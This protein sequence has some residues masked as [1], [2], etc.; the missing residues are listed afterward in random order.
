M[1]C[2]MLKFVEIK[3]TL[4][5]IINASKKINISKNELTRA[6]DKK[7]F[8]KCLKDKK[9][10]TFIEVKIIGI[11]FINLNCGVECG[12]GI[13]RYIETQ[14]LNI[15]KNSLV[16]RISGTKFG[17]Y[18]NEIDLESIKDIIEE[19]IEIAK[20]LN[21]CKKKMKISLN[22]AAIIYT[23]DQFNLEDSNNKIALCMSS[24]IKNGENKYQIYNEKY[25]RDISIKMIEKAIDNGEIVLHYQPKVEVKSNKIQGVEAL[26]RWFKNGNIYI[27]SQE[28][29]AFTEESGYIN[30]LGKWII[31]TACSEIK[32]LNDITKSDVGLSINIS[33]KQLQEEN[34]L[35]EVK[36]KIE[37]LEFDNKLLKFEITENE[38]IDRIDTVQ[39][40]FNSIKNIGI[41]VSMDDFGKGYNSIDYIK[42][43]NVDEIKIDKSLVVYINDNPK[44]IKYLINMIHTTNTLV[45]AE[46]VEEQHEYEALKEM[47]CDLIQ[48]YYFFK[49]MNLENLIEVVKKNNRK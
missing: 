15:N 24:A 30:T 36:E 8:F 19:I 44:F 49:P 41:E 20:D 9:N 43:Y 6:Y 13:I 35:K 5:K 16:G 45:V 22:I 12:D 47:G 25:K 46:G 2:Y 23:N 48:G 17:I 21:V 39:T 40:I 29:I 3:N 34:F 38:N 26:I 7:K 4:K 11:S 10:G 1:Q 31:S 32:K 37:Q 18:T 28:L 33:P 42:K 27:P 14:L